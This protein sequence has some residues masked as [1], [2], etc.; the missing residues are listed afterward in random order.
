MKDLDPLVLLA[1]FQEM[2]GMWLWPLV[3]ALILAPAFFAAVLVR[4]RGFVARRLVASQGAGL[5]GGVL[6]LVIMVRVS[7][8]GYTDAGGPADWFLI[9]L[10][11]GAGLVAGTV[12]AYTVAGWWALSRRTRRQA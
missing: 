11:F 10:L 8:S 2:L 7:S 6:A 9:A 4:E 12:L 3:L 5:V 1:V